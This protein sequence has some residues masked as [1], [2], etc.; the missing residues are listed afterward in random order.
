MLQHD[1]FDEPIENLSYDWI[2]SANEK[3]ILD[4]EAKIESL[5][6]ETASKIF[7]IVVERSGPLFQ[8]DDTLLWLKEIIGHTLNKIDSGDVADKDILVA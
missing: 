3:S 8:D 4:D 6:D 2:V 5:V 7:N 1:L